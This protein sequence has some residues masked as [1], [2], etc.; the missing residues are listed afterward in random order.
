MKWFVKPIL[1][2]L[3]W[4]IGIALLLAALYFVVRWLLLRDMAT[5]GAV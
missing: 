1:V 2:G 4:V 5:S 3:A